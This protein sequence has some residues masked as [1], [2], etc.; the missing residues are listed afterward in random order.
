MKKTDIFEINDDVAAI[1]CAIEHANLKIEPATQSKLT[2][3]YHD[4][5]G[6]KVETAGE[7]LI[8]VQ[9]LSGFARLL[10]LAAQPLTIKVPTHLVPSVT[11][12][13][14]N[15][16]VY[17]ENGI[18]GAFEY[19]SKRGGVK[20]ENAMLASVELKGE[21]VNIAIANSTIKGSLICSEANGNV[22]LDNIFAAHIDCRVKSGDVGAANLNCRDSAFEANRG[23]VTATV[24]GNEKAFGISL[25]A[26]DGTCNRESAKKGC[27]EAT[28]KAYS[29]KGNI[30]VDFIFADKEAAL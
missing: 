23:N 12:T 20:I 21:S 17:I 14:D 25:T 5:R 6:F 9:K 10:K 19:K 7:R 16:K 24:L 30:F 28:F 15:A 18:Y 29:A 8:I 2:V 4:G 27:E 26:K 1:S 11:V 3:E 13:A 22:N